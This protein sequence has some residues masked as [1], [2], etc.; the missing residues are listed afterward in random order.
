MLVTRLTDL[1]GC[2][3]PAIPPIG[4]IFGTFLLAQSRSLDSQ[5][6]NVDPTVFLASL[7]Q[8]GPWSDFSNCKSGES[9]AMARKVRPNHEALCE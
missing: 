6:L 4:L 8:K 9:N 3:L 2:I 7:G 5:S 1:G